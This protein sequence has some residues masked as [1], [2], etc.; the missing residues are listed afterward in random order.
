MSKEIDIKEIQHQRSLKEFKKIVHGLESI[1]LDTNSVYTCC[2]SCGKLIKSKAKKFIRR[3]ELGSGNTEW[4]VVFK[5]EP[6]TH[7]NK[8]VKS[9]MELIEKRREY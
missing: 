9:I 8:L 3:L 1:N 6:C 7:C 5:V 2:S 4:G